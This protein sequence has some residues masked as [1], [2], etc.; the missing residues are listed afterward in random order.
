MSRARAFPAP[1]AASVNIWRH[2]GRVG[3]DGTALDVLA[4][5]HHHRVMVRRRHLRAQHVTQ[6]DNFPVGIRGISTPMADLPGIGD[7]IRTSA[8]FT[9][10]RCSSISSG[11]P[12]HLHRRAKLDLV[13]GHRR[14][15]GEAGHL[16]VYLKLIQHHRQ[17]LDHRVIGPR[18]GLRRRTWRRQGEQA[19]AS[20]GVAGCGLGQLLG[21]L[22]R[23]SAL[24]PG[25]RP[26]R[27]GGT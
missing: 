14:P 18:P 3:H 5:R 1:V 26:G 16:G 27:R 24:R 22:R 10:P 23:R 4:Q 9:A 11:D 2:L 12:L 20:A 17:R 19:A 7:R 21:L 25:G 15:P 13:P 8:L 6:A